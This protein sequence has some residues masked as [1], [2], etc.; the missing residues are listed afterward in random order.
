MKE[1]L[2]KEQPNISCKVIKSKAASQNGIESKKSLS[3]S[4]KEN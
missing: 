4:E 2:S 1:P 3:N